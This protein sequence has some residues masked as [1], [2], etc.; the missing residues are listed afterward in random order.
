MDTG[1]DFH[2]LSGLPVYAVWQGMHQRCYNPA[3]VSFPDY[4]GRGIR[5]CDR[6]LSV[7]AFME[8]MGHP[9]DGMTIGR[10][11]NDGNYEPGNCRWETQEQ[12]NENTRRN[13]YITWQGRTQTIK[14]WA[15]ELDLEPR[16]ISERIRRGWSVEKALTTPTPLGYQDGREQHNSRTRAVWAENG[17]RYRQATAAR[18]NGE[19]PCDVSLAA[20]ARQDARKR[21]NER[22][23]ELSASGMTCR[24]ISD[25]LGVSKSTVASVLAAYQ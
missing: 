19:R 17:K 9:P 2:G 13:R 7:H 3:C 24:A 22:I 25:E 14:A 12:Q 6:W 8:D 21:R 20:R 1:I 5:I 11:N 4:G 16:R 15:Q 23:S 10:I 18:R